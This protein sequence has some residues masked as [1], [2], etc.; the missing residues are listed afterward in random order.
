[1]AALQARGVPA[2]VVQ[3][4][5]DM[6][7]R[8]PHLRAR[9]YYQYLDHAETGRSA[10]EGVCARLGATPGRHRAPAPLF[11]EH[12]EDVCRRI[13]GLGDDEIADLLAEGVLA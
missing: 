7:E 3:N 5:R 10:Y 1:M 12:T 9:G 13:L 8:D 2:G 11:G 4:A 6:L